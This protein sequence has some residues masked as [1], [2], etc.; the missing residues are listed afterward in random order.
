VEV[1]QIIDEVESGEFTK[2]ELVSV[3]KACAVTTLLQN[4]KD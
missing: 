3:A 2:D 1:N 4:Y